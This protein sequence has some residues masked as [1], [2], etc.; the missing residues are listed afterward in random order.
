MSMK[1]Q[2]AMMLSSLDIDLSNIQ[3]FERDIV[4]YNGSYRIIISNEIDER[5]NLFC[6]FEIIYNEKVSITSRTI[7]SCHTYKYFA[8]IFNAIKE[9]INALGDINLDFIASKV[10]EA[11]IQDNYFVYTTKNP[12]SQT[13]V[14]NNKYSTSTLGN[15]FL[16]TFLNEELSYV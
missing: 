3:Y 13:R 11:N 16:T 9:S 2:I 7:D 14:L 15:T 10:E 1:L 6:W 8:I 5:L 4:V 12:V